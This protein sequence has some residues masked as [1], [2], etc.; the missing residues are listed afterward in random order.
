MRTRE[1]LLLFFIDAKTGAVV[2]HW[3]DKR[4]QTA[5]VGQGTG[6]W[7]DTRYNVSGTLSFTITGNRSNLAASG[8]I[9]LQQ[10]GLGDE[11]GTATGTI[12]G[13]RLS[14]KRCQP[15]NPRKLLG[16]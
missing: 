9:G 3:S 11:T 1:D 4:T 5:S 12:S 6:T 2:D 14:F 10:L 7:E 16:A 15:V 13:N 8:T